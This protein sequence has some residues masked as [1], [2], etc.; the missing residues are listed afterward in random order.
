LQQRQLSGDV[1]GNQV[2]PGREYLA[3]LDENRP[4]RFERTAQPLPAWCFRPSPQA[5]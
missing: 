4:E 1:G 5:G 2:A 3:E